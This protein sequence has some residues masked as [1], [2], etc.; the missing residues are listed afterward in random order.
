MW[1]A[2]RSDENQKRRTLINTNGIINGVY[3]MKNIPKLFVTAFALTLY[4]QGT[5]AATI[6]VDP[7]TKTVVGVGETFSL[8]IVGSNF[9]A[10]A[11]GT[12]GGGFSASWDSAILSLDSYD[13][14]FSGDQTVGEDCVS[15]AGSL[16]N[17]DV[18]SFI[19]TESSSFQIA[20]LTFNS[21]ALG[22]SAIDLEIGFFPVDSAVDDLRRLWA[23]SSGSVDTNPGFVDGR[24][25]V[26]PIPAAAWLFGSGLIGLAGIGRRRRRASA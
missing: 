15:S 14:T 11:G 16:S 2:Q 21:L 8:D 26:V 24:V 1:L 20:T 13:L 9:T 19:G 7:A 6:S 12:V 3:P 22:D 23:D 25:Q 17:C 18:T 4:M 5:Q 10:G